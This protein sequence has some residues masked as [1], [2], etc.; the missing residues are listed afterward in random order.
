MGG[1]LVVVPYDTV[2]F[3]YLQF[4]MC[5]RHHFQE[6]SASCKR[7]GTRV[8]LSTHPTGLCISFTLNFLVVETP[9]TDTTVLKHFTI[10]TVGNHHVKLIQK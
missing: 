4:E 2:P 10:S 1:R 7:A 3:I 6:L 9:H 5:T 8:E